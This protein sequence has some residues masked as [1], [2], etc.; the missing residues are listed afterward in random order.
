MEPVKYPSMPWD[1][2][3]TQ[4]SEE[5][6]L[7]LSD[8]N[9]MIEN[10]TFDDVD[11]NASAKS[12]VIKNSKAFFANPDQQLNV[13]LSE[14]LIDDS[15][16]W[17]S[18]LL[19]ADQK[20]ASYGKQKYSSSGRW[21]RLKDISALKIAKQKFLAPGCSLVITLIADELRECYRFFYGKCSKPNEKIALDVFRTNVDM[22]F[23]TV[24]EAGVTLCSFMGSLSVQQSVEVNQQI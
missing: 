5:E 23:A 20:I 11:P 15:V 24:I 9:E 13:R 12:E 21:K 10:G 8:I 22:L 2:A 7:D 17:Q 1:M 14:Q 19:N 4:N 18:P 3:I 16:V 6:V